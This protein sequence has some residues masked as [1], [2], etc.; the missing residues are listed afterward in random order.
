MWLAGA[1]RS[2]HSTS[3][4]TGRRPIALAPTGVAVGVGRD[5]LSHDSALT[6]TSQGI[7]P[8][9]AIAFA[10]AM[11]VKDGRTTDGV[12]RGVR[13]RDHGSLP[14]KTALGRLRVRFDPRRAQPQE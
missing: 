2:S 7:A 8:Q 13:V 11:K 12:E 1:R 6:S 3:P 4:L 14:T 10:L 9:C 5:D